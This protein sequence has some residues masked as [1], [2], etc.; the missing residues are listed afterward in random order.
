MDA[1]TIGAVLLAILS[2]A[3]G[4][5][6]SQLWA[7]LTALVRRPLHRDQDAESSVA[8]SLEPAPSGE[9]E[10]AA[11]A[12][13]PDDERKA[14]VLAEVLLARAR[15]DMTFGSALENWWEQA[16][17]VRF[18]QE[19]ITNTVTVRNN[20]GTILQGDF[21]NARID[22]ILRMPAAVPVALAQLPPPVTGF[23]GRS[24]ELDMLMAVLDPNGAAR[25]V[26]VSAVA[27]LAGVGKTAL[28]IQAAHTAR[29]RGW[30]LGGE[31]FLNLHGYDEKPVEPPQAL[32]ALLRALGVDETHIP[33]GAEARAGLYRS[34]LARITKPILIIADNVSSEAQVRLLLPGTGPH[35]MVVTSRHTLA[36][37]GA[38]LLDVTVLDKKTGVALLDAALRAARPD[39]ERITGDL[40][41][42]GQLATICGG[43]PLALQIVAA[44]LKSDP[45]RGVSELAD[46]LAD[47]QMRLERLQYDDGSRTGGPSVIAAFEMSCRSLDRASA[48]VFRL[49]PVNPGPDLSTAATAALA[50]MSVAEAY[51]VLTGLARAHL[52]EVAPGRPG[53]WRMHDLLHLYARQQGNAYAD[54]DRRE[55]A[56]ER[57]LN[58]YLRG[59]ESA[60]QHLAGQS[61][62]A[63]PEGFANRGEALDWLDAER[64]NTVAAVPVAADT[65]RSQ[66]A[67]R[68]P[69]TLAPYLDWRR[70]FDDMLATTTISLDT[71]R[72][73]GDRAS[74]GMA[75]N[76]LGITLWREQRFEE[77]IIACQDAAA[78]FQEIGDRAREGRAL[79]NLG[80]SMREAGRIE[81]S[82][83]AHRNAAEIFQMAG[84]L[85]YEGIALNNLGGAFR[86]AGR[87]EDAITACQD[88]IAIFREIGDQNEE[89]KAL[90][91]LHLATERN[92]AY[93]A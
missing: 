31:I 73:L 4:Q 58:Y 81:E 78:I 11:L 68:L 40:E 47:N 83:A 74:E 35:R 33:P 51:G 26:V 15:T 55:E 44:M 8:E 69:M 60:Q 89:T 92:A 13:A 90:H 24:S 76:I 25:A 53:R 88:A 30:C 36:D 12:Q 19:K 70:R 80:I 21:R 17:L 46:E 43:L 1:V 65:G 62:V 93:E 34:V 48:R 18:R 42:A 20:Y 75:L 5:V 63:A 52:V 29:M 9:A 59:A 66:I 23:T 32:D 2:G 41:G 49:I 6:G 50:G 22:L 39:D 84:D 45:T 77:A 14:L 16:A 27:G 67:L 85:R 7:G 71:A 82:I 56:T 87:P 57:L 28:A 10:L 79:T 72:G 38:R 54:A 37:L 86:Q 61:G 91:N 3:G 64:E